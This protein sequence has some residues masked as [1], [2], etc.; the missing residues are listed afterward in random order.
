MWERIQQ[1]FRGNLL[2]WFGFFFVGLLIF[3]AVFAPQLATYDIHEIDL[4]GRD[5]PPSRNHWMGTDDLGRDVYSRVLYGARVS[6]TVGVLSQGVSLGVGISL[7]MM[8][9]FFRGWTDHLVMWLVNVVWAFP[10]LLLV[11][12]IQIA[13]P[14]EPWTI[15]FAI[16]LAGWVPVARIVR[17]EVLSLRERE[18]IEAARSLGFSPFRVMFRHILPNIAPTLI[19]VAT[20]GLATAIIA[21]AALSFLGLGIQPPDPSWGNMILSGYTKIRYAWWQAFFPSIAIMLSVLSFN[22]LGDAFSTRRI[23]V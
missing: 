14:N 18:F 19:V 2:A 10:Y 20:L 6:L 7:G 11:L 1:T 15:F 3:V 5:Q 8:A 22:L 4:S 12:A 16:G 23:E 21:E 17:G 13:L 9:G